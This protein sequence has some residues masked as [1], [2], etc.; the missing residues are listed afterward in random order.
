MP[1]V[2]FP[3]RLLYFNALFDSLQIPEKFILRLCN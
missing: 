1:K 3:D 2:Q